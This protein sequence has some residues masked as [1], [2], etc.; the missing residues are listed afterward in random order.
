MLTTIAVNSMT[1]AAGVDGRFRSNRLFSRGI[2]AYFAY[3]GLDYGRELLTNY[4]V[5]SFVGLTYYQRW[6]KQTIVICSRS[7]LKLS[8][9]VR[10]KEQQA[11]KGPVVCF[12]AF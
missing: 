1:T 5:V 8:L 2:L 10:G 7:P 4:F 9:F 3:H 6:Y 11:K 12:V